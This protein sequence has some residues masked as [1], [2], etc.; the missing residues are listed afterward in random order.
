MFDW[1]SSLIVQYLT[2]TIEDLMWLGEFFSRP[3]PKAGRELQTELNRREDE[4]DP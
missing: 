1:E 2:K 4:E 3:S